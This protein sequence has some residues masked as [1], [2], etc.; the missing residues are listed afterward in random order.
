[1][2]QKAFQALL[3]LSILFVVGCAPTEQASDGG[4][5]GAGSGGSQKPT[6]NRINWDAIPQYYN[7]SIQD[8]QFYTE[9][10]KKVYVDYFGFKEDAEVIYSE[11]VPLGTGFIRSYSVW[12]GSASWGALSTH[13]Q[14]HRLNL[15]RVGN[16]KCTIQTENGRITVLQGGCYIRL[17]IILPKGSEIEVYNANQ[18]ISKESSTIA[19]DEFL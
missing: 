12:T 1:M 17:Q 9:N 19:T 16:Y 7:P 11:Q 3:I 14:N 18:K 6:S 8:V 10:F 13:S 5:G 15:K 4:A 2:F